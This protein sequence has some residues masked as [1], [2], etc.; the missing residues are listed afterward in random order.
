MTASAVL[1]TVFNHSPASHSASDSNISSARCNVTR[2]RILFFIRIPK[3]ASTSFVDLLRSLASASHFTLLFN[4]SGAYDWDD[5]TIR[6]EADLVKSNNGKVVYARHFYYTSFEEYG[7]RNFTYTTVIRDP[8]NRFISS[9]LYYHYSSKKHIQRML[10]PKYKHETILECTARKHNGCAH[11]WLTKYFCGHH[12][13]CSAG[14]ADAL[15]VAKANMQKFAVVGVLEEIDLSLKVFRAV[16]PGFFATT[17]GATVQEV[18]PLSNKNENSMVLSDEERAIVLK[19]NSADMELYE[20]AKSL[21][22]TSAI[23][24]DLM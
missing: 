1:P 16:L 12:K 15:A 8:V 5:V 21:L 18:L 19:A 17:T 2:P 10:K 24:C 3:S 9:F 20:Y 6:K 22:H 13:R 11:N 23:S 7:V 14:D 4:P